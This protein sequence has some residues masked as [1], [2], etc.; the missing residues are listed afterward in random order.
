MTRVTRSTVAALAGAVVLAAP[1]APALAAGARHFRHF[2]TAR[3]VPHQLR[4]HRR[5]LHW[6]IQEPLHVV[7]VRTTKSWG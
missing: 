7:V 4:H 3:A 2:D 5:H 1:S 6:T